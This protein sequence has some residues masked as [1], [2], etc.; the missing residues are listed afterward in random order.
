MAIDEI[1]AGLELGRVGV[2]PEAFLEH[3]LFVA[4][5]EAGPRGRAGRVVLGLVAAQA[6]Y[7]ADGAA[8]QIAI[9]VCG[10]LSPPLR[11]IPGH[12]IVVNSV[13]VLRPRPGYSGRQRFHGPLRP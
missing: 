3:G 7:V 10:H 9:V 8:E 4:T 1:L 5:P 6:A 11:V 12:L 13:G 2:V